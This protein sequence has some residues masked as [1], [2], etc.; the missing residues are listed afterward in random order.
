MSQGGACPKAPV[1]LVHTAAVH[2]PPVVGAAVRLRA[3][4]VGSEDSTATAPPEGA[5]VHVYY[6]GDLGGARRAWAD[7][8]RV[9]A[10]VLMVRL[11]GQA[12]HMPEAPLP[13]HSLELQA[14]A[15][16]HPLRLEDVAVSHVHDGYVVL[17]VEV[18]ECDV[19]EDGLHV[20][21]IELKAF[22]N[23]W[24]VRGKDVPCLRADDSVVDV[25]VTKL[26]RAPR[27]IMCL[28]VLKCKVR[29]PGGP[30]RTPEEQ[31]GPAR[32]DLRVRKDKAPGLTGGRGTPRDVA[33]L[34][35]A[36]G[37]LP[38]LAANVHASATTPEPPRGVSSVGIKLQQFL[39]VG[40]VAFIVRVTVAQ[41]VGHGRKVE[42]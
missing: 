37:I 36:F 13:G 8:A 32:K 35:A 11:A 18:A 19:H 39:C 41:H 38:E 33:V 29:R 2:P 12:M 23:S 7:A 24:H 28:K 4:V 40:L 17:S 10:G 30:V 3:G 25:C 22:R 21:V 20:R 6:V 14:L 16:E 31:P 42:T 15:M 9:L 26:R 5:A 1:L 27:D 34:M